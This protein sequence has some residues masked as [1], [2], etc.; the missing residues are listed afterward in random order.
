MAMRKEPDI[1]PRLPRDGVLARRLRDLTSGGTERRYRYM[2]VG[3]RTPGGSTFYYLKAYVETWRDGSLADEDFAVSQLPIRDDDHGARRLFERLTGVR[4]PVSPAHVADVLRDLAL[5]T[6][7]YVP[8]R[9]RRT[10][11]G[12]YDSGKGGVARDASLLPSD[13]EPHGSSG[14]LEEQ[15][16]ASPSGD[17]VGPTGRLEQDERWSRPLIVRRV[18]LRPV[19]KRQ[20]AP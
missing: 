15:G 8:S 4:I 17:G 6:P 9:W 1:A 13:R 11:R 19:A 16:H 20:P 18:T 10:R 7:G 5:V 3:E 12:K 14:R 2:L